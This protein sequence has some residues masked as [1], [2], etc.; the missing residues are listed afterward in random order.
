MKTPFYK[1]WCFWTFVTVVITI[2]VLFVPMI[3]V[4]AMCSPCAEPPAYC[5][6]CPKYFTTIFGY[7][8]D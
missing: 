5:P 3:P 1:N 7:L 8:I 2:I 4:Q 6:P